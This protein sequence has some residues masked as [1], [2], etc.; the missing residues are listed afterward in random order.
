MR[1]TR[2]GFVAVLSVLALIY[3]CYPASEVTYSNPQNPGNVASQ[4]MIEFKTDEA[5]VQL[6]LRYRRE[7]EDNGFSYSNTDRKSVV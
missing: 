4:W 5:K 2:I 7:R 6:T 1:Y 3:A